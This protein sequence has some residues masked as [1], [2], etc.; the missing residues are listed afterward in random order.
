MI[1]R[2]DNLIISPH[3]GFGGMLESV[4]C[5][6]LSVI[7]IVYVRVINGRATEMLAAGGA[8]VAL[9][10]LMFL[11]VM[12]LSVTVSLRADERSVHR[13]AEYV[14]IASSFTIP[15]ARLEY[16]VDYCSIQSGSC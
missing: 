14:C 1:A 16:S 9:F 10:V 15:V 7:E 2:R 4:Y 8:V 12:H 13:A 5:Y 3:R 6:D 11:Y